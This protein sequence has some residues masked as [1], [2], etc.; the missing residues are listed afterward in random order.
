LTQT[1]VQC[2]SSPANSRLKEAT[3]LGYKKT[4]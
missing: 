3:V 2:I 1:H 4:L